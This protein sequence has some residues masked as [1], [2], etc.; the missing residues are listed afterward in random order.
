MNSGTKTKI[1]RKWKK[2][3]GD[4]EKITKEKRRNKNGRNVT[5]K[6]RTMRKNTKKSTHENKIRKGRNKKERRKAKRKELGLATSWHHFTWP[7]PQHQA[8]QTHKRVSLTAVPQQMRVLIVV[9]KGS[10]MSPLGVTARGTVGRRGSAVPR[11]SWPEPDF[12]IPE[13]DPEPDFISIPDPSRI[14]PDPWT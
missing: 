12:K 1:K 5:D 4:T 3:E 14:H 6:D 8:T 7:P 9:K 10:R 2:G 11:G 13:P